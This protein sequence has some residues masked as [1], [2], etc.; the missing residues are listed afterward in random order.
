[1][2]I[3]TSLRKK[4]T[5]ED[6]ANLLKCIDKAKLKR[7]KLTNCFQVTGR[8]LEPLENFFVLEQLD[9]SLACQRQNPDNAS[10]ISLSE[11]VV[12][13]ILESIIEDECSL[14]QHVQFPQQWRYNQSQEFHTFLVKYDNFLRS[15]GL[16]Y[17]CY[18]VIDREEM[19][20]QERKESY[21]LQE[22]TC[23]HCMKT[24]C[25]SCVD[26]GF[27]DV[28]SCNQCQKVY[29]SDCFSIEYCHMCDMQSCSACSMIN[30]CVG[31]DTHFCDSCGTGNESDWT[32]LGRV[33]IE[34]MCRSGVQP[35]QYTPRTHSPDLCSM[36]FS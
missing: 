22:L 15:R 28:D 29:C 1:M 24:A 21:G 8:C 7:L 2:D 27:I 14:L 11:Q 16:C 30:Y 26:H 18:Q 33:P 3:D 5:D 6:I 23:Y 36:L 20:D 9:L 31:C 25:R 17:S 13:P 19:L 34:P 4:L 35:L 10:S 32:T 12:L